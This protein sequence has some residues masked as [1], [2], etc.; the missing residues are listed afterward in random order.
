M[1]AC[2]HFY[3]R[4]KYGDTIHIDRDVSVYEKLGV[5]MAGIG[6]AADLGPGGAFI[7]KGE[8][9]MAIALRTKAEP[10]FA[11]IDALVTQPAKDEFSDTIRISLRGAGVRSGD[12]LIAVLQETGSHAIITLDYHMSVFDTLTDQKMLQHLRAMGDEE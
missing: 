6:G 2:L 10:A 5:A 1:W 9:V 4:K 8:P 7:V 3:L 12:R 11:L